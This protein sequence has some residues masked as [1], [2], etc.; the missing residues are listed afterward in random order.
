MGLKLLS[1]GIL[2]ILHACR[3]FGFFPDEQFQDD[4]FS[5]SAF[6]PFLNFVVNIL[7]ITI[8]FCR[9]YL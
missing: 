2:C 1:A 3:H 5:S 6:I 4:N 8:I 9:L 7:V